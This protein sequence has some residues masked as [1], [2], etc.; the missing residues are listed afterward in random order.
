MDP[1]FVHTAAYAI[2]LLFLFACYG[3]ISDFSFFRATFAEY[4]LVPEWLSAWGAAGVVLA[5]AGI[6]T[7]AFYRP[8]MPVAMRVAA[9]LLLV[10]AAAIAVN[11]W[12][13]RRDLD[14]GCMGPARRQLISW[15]LVLR[16]VILAGLALVGAAAPAAR[17]LFAA[18]FVLIALTL[19]GATALYGAINQLMINAPRLRSLDSLP[20]GA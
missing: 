19:L 1:I 17:P 2:A 9:L 7:L 13:G 3:K 8:A 10:Y 20:D 14:C 6:V 15:W 18:D 12:R 16:N 4:Q 5:E 11:L